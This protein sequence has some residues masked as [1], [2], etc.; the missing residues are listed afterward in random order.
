MPHKE[1][2]R[3][4]LPHFQQPGQAYFVTWCLKDAVPKHALK[5][6]TEEL[7]I[8][9]SRIGEAGKA[10]SKPL[11]KPV[12]WNR[13]DSEIDLVLKKLKEKYYALRKK[14]IKAFN[15]YLDVQKNPSVDIS[16]PENTTIIRNAL[17]YWENKK[18]INY[19]FCVMPNHVHWV[20]K[21]LEKDLEGNPVYLEDIL[22]SVKRFT[23]TQINKIECRN[24]ALWQKESFE[25]T[26]RDENHLYYAIEYT[27]NN[28]VN[29]G[30][31]KERDE[32]HGLWSR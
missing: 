4:N 19:A 25:T 27:L 24:G 1:H 15:D 23:S 16:K 29:T 10:V 14:Y 8:L 28:P 18:L 3:L 30:F 9:K 26:I 21:L 5:R 22:Y 17:K 12:D 6:Y 13:Q 20:I 31:V 11:L 7:Q 2:Y 32:W